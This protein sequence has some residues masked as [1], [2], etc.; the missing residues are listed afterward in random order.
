MTY[1][2]SESR[3]SESSEEQVAISDWYMQEVSSDHV[4]IKVEF[5]DPHSV[6]ESCLDKDEL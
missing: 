3:S 4:I 2:P 6:S 1:E 5:T